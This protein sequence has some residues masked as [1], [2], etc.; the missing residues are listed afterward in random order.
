[1]GLAELDLALGTS[2][3]ILLDRSLL[4]AFYNAHELV[5]SLAR[6]LMARIE[7]KTD[8]LRGYYSAV[9]LM[10]L[11]VRPMAVGPEVADALM[12]S[13]M[14]FPNLHLVP[15]D[16]VIGRQA[17]ELRSKQRISPADALVVAS[18]LAAGCGAIVSNDDRWDKRL[19]AHYPAVK[20]IYLDANR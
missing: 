12:A 20:F 10:E 7:S 2:E 18:S 8:P 1:V 17:A 15:I 16:A 3:D 5:H 11:L 13:L 14:R 9:S 4:I 19:A 6:H